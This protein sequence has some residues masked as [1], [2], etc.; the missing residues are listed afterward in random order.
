VSGTK[1]QSCGGKKEYKGLLFH[2]LRRTGVRNMIRNGIS[3]K[4]A[5]VI[6]GHKTR[7]VFDRYN[8]TS[9]D[10]LVNAGQKIRDG[11]ERIK[12]QAKEFDHRTATVNNEV[13]SE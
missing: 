9:Y 8:I 12:Q 1:F 3:E 5:M 13:G 4:V 7:S 10:D 2:D 6:S 11:R